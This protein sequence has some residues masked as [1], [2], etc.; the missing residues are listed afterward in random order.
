MSWLSRLG[1]RQRLGVVRNVT[2]S[3]STLAVTFTL[4]SIGSLT[5]PSLLVVL[6]TDR[7]GLTNGETRHHLQKKVRSYRQLYVESVTVHLEF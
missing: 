2:G 1:R 6:R 7:I 4:Y 5:F 3:K